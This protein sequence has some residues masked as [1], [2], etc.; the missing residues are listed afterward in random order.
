MVASKFDG[1]K[2]TFRNI[3]IKSLTMLVIWL[4]NSFYFWFASNFFTYVI[5]LAAV[6]NGR[7]LDHVGLFSSSA[8]SKWIKVT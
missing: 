6:L 1:Y 8:F 5:S 3:K 7:G 4:Q 2:S